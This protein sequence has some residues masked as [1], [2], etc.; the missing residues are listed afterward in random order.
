MVIVI[1]YDLCFCF[2]FFLFV[3]YSTGGNDRREVEGGRE[4]RGTSTYPQRRF[5]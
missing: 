2:F 5:F 1:V 3:Q 4:R